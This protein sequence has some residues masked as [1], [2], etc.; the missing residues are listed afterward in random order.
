MQAHFPRSRC[1]RFRRA[2]N[3]LRDFNSQNPAGSINP[4]TQGVLYQYDPN[5]NLLWQQTVGGASTGVSEHEAA[6]HYYWLP[7]EHG[8]ILIGFDQGIN[9]YA[10]Y[11]DHLNT[12]RLVTKIDNPQNPKALTD[13][14][15]DLPQV[16][17]GEPEGISPLA[18]P[19]WQ[20]SYSPFGADLANGYEAKPTTLANNFKPEL[21]TWVGL[22]ET[23]GADPYQV[24]Q[25]TWRIQANLSTPPTLNI[26]YPGQY[27]DFEVGLVQN[28]WRTYEPRI[29]RYVSA[30][31]IGLDGGWNRFAYVEGDGI[32]NYD[33]TGLKMFPDDFTGPLPRDGYRRSEMKKTRCG[34]VPPAP[35]NAD[36]D[37]NMAEAKKRFDP[38]WFKNQVKN[39]AP[40]DYKQ[41]GSKYQDFGNFNYGAAGKSFGFYAQTLRQEAGRAQ[42]AA[43]TSRSEWGFPP[44]TYFDLYGS[45]A[46]YGD[47]PDDQQQINAGIDYCSCMGY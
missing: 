15:N 7:N 28:W 1:R 2:G 3:T 26:R 6:T 42:R 45:Q 47:D 37:K 31:P 34:L 14:S 21:W 46:P 12:P 33:P 16:S 8:D 44:A 23:G 32:N 25:E 35:P 5:G 38:R 4:S 13:T 19:V 29:G 24:A 22:P 41:Q 9:S 27:Y 30:D 43:G 40:W 20:W 18:I 39:K 11:T 17:Y 10:V 36:V